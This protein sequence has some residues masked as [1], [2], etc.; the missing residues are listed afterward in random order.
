MSLE[1]EL[2]GIGASSR[3]T[4][5]EERWGLYTGVVEYNDDPKNTG[6]VKVRIGGIHPSAQELPAEKLPWANVL[7]QAFGMQVPPVGATVA[8][9]FILGKLWQ[10]MVTGRVYGNLPRAHVVGRLAY[11]GEPAGINTEPRMADVADRADPNANNDLA[12][13]QPEGNEAP[14][15]S[16]KRRSTT[17]PTITVIVDSLRG[18]TIYTD[19]APGQEATKIID[20]LGAMLAFHAPVS[21]SANRGNMNRRDDHEAVD[22][23]QLPFDVVDGEARVTLIDVLAQFLKMTA[24][25]NATIRLQGASTDGSGSPE[26]DPNI[27]YIQISRSPCNIEIKCQ[28]NGKITVDDGVSLSDNA[29]DLVDLHGGTVTVSGVAAVNVSAAVINLN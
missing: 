14:I 19:D 1:S 27:N 25:G 11:L 23:T 15:V 28:L 10:P 9:Q 7:Q 22:G 13:E 24:G 6:R 4:Q 16:F 2:P 20:R 17:S 21:Q 18:S 29:G 5:H 3:R 26:N 12:Y 8:V